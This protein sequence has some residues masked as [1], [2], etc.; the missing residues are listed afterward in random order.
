MQPFIVEVSTKIATAVNKS[1]KQ[2]KVLFLHQQLTAISAVQY[3]KAGN[4]DL[5]ST[6]NAVEDKDEVG[7][8]VHQVNA[9][10]ASTEVCCIASIEAHLKQ[11]PP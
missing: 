9:L 4:S 3:L 1:S 10:P 5:Y 11:I 7:A 2:Q 6:R 8:P